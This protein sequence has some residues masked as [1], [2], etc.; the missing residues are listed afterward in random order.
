MDERRAYHRMKRAF[1][2]ADWQ[3]I[4]NRVGSGAPDV[5]VCHQGVEMWIEL[6]EGRIGRDNCVRVR[7]RPPQRAWATRRLNA[8][9][10]VRLA[11]MLGKQCYILPGS[12]IKDFRWE[13]GIAIEELERH[14]IPLSQLFQPP[15][16]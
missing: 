1:P 16:I 11:L 15:V 5:N 4:E 8:K 14:A 2:Q 13:K 10:N 12:W 7:I 6:K 9:G 3:R